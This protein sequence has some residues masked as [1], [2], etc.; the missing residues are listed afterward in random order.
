M[1]T[2]KGIAHLFSPME[3]AIRTKLLPVL[4][5]THFSEFHRDVFRLP[6]RNGGLVETTLRRHEDEKKRK[7]LDRVIQVEKATFTPVVFST[8]GAMG[9]DADRLYKRIAKN[10][11]V[12]NKNSYADTIRYIRQRLAFCLLKTTVISLRGYRGR[13]PCR[14]DDSVDYNLLYLK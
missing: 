6:A 11:S 7:Y 3:D 2:T 5:G 13:R 14:V 10:L 4:I 9:N 8:S 1:R 12:K